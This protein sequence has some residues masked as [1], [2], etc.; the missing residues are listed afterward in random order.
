MRERERMIEDDD[1][2]IV[3]VTRRVGLVCHCKNIYSDNDDVLLGNFKLKNDI[4]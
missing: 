1:R 2:D 3:W 4:I